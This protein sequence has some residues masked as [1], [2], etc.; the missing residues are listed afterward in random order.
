MQVEDRPRQFQ[1]VWQWWEGY[2]D[3]VYNRLRPDAQQSI[4]LIEHKV[5]RQQTTPFIF[6]FYL[7]PKTDTDVT[8]LEARP[9]ASTAEVNNITGKYR[10]ILKH[11]GV[12]GMQ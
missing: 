4:M 9:L 1:R 10:P 5:K 3:A 8:N 12:D 6:D 2:Y 7:H 11:Y